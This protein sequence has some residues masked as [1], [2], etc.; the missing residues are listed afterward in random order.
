MNPV[1][2]TPARR[3]LRN[4]SGQVLP[5]MAVLMLA[6]LVMAGYVLDY[7]RALYTYRQ[8]QASCDAA[9]LAGAQSLPLTSALLVA[10]QYSSLAGN[11]NARQTLTNVSMVSG[12][13]KIVCLNTLKAEGQACV[14]PGYGNAIVV[15]QQM[16]VP[17]Y[18]MSLVGIKTM[19]VAASATAAM[20]GASPSPYNVAII[21][22]TTASMNSFDSD[23]N[24]SNTRL[25]CALAGMQVLLQNLSPCGA[26]IADC[27]SPTNGNVANAVDR[28][29]LYTFPG[30]TSAAQAQNDY[31]CSGV[32]PQIAPYTDPVLPTYQ[33]VG[34]SSDYRKANGSTTLNTKSDLSKSSGGVD[35][36]PG[37]QAKGGYGTYYAGILYAAQ[38]D[39][40]AQAQAHPGTKNVMILLSD[41]DANAP[42]SAM[43]NASNSSG[44]YPSSKNQ[45]QQAVTAAAAAAAAGTKVY[46]VAYGATSAG[47]STDTNG[48]T[49]CSTM[50]QIAS[51][52]QNF[53]SDYTAAGGAGSC[54]SAAQP[55]S[56]L[57]VIFTQIAGA[58]TVARLIPDNTP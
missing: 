47:C 33:V 18:F 57:S 22:D 31:N 40:A 54:I 42:A 38:A 49:P 5:F 39:L 32:A 15:K 50:E 24:C 37:M 23:S 1:Q 25:S 28:V 41:G 52:P 36:C 6:L 19:N 53:F 51:A 46:S 30:L 21:I 13:P 17:L 8:L 58:L 7:G 29:S 56:N 10:K 16:T 43:P 14:A 44:V 20:R 48:L 4:E 45:C 55:T 27:G 2:P 26:A 11:L 12:Y 3:F 9:A 35:N 34:Y